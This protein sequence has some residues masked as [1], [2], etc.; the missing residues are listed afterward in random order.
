M[1][2]ADLCCDHDKNCQHR[3]FFVKNSAVDFPINFVDCGFFQFSLAVNMGIPKILLSE[4][5]KF[6]KNL[7]CRTKN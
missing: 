6:Q 7:N 1:G 4:T 5:I 3:S 2:K